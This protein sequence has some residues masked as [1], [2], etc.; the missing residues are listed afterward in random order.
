MKNL[1]EETWRRLCTIVTE[2]KRLCTWPLKFLGED[3]QET[4]RKLRGE[5]TMTTTKVSGR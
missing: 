2:T 5:E 4:T 3:D 1:V